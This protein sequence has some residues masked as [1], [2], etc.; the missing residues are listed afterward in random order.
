MTPRRLALVV[1]LA[2]AVAAPRASASMDVTPGW[3]TSSP[4]GRSLAAHFV[5]RAGDKLLVGGGWDGTFLATAWAY[6]AASD[7]WQPA[8]AMNQARGNATAT[9][10][11]D[12]R[13]LVAGGFAPC[14]PLASA[15]I[16]DPALDRWKTVA[17]MAAARTDH[18]AVRLA[19]G[20]VLVLGGSIDGA[21]TATATIYDP[22]SDKWSAAAPMTT[23]RMH[24]TATLLPNGRVLV[25]GGQVGNDALAS[26]EV[27]DPT[28]NQWNP[29][30]PM[31]VGR[32]VHTATLLPNGR[33]LVVG[34]R[35]SIT[36]AT[37]SAELFD[38]AGPSWSSA[39]TMSAGRDGHAAILLANGDVL[40]AGSEYFGGAATTSEIYHPQRNAWDPPESMH[41]G[42]RRHGVGGLLLDGRVVLV[43]GD[44]NYAASV[45]TVRWTPRTTQ[46]YP[47][48]VWDLGNQALG[49]SGAPQEL[50]VTNT[51]DQPLLFSGATTVG[52]SAAEFKVAPGGC[53]TA[54]VMPGQSCQ[55]G[56][57]FTP[58]APGQRRA[59]FTFTSNAN[60]WP[61]PSID[62]KG[63]GVS[64][65]PAPTSTTTP[66]PTPEA[67]TE[68]TPGPHP[69]PS[70]TPLIPAPEATR[71]PVPSARSATASIVFKNA[72]RIARPLQATRCRGKITLELRKGPVRLARRT[73]T[74]DRRCRFGTTFTVQRSRIG[75][76]KSLTVVAHFHG[77]RY[78]GATTNR[79]KV[80]V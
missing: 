66:S 44:G 59:T 6:S 3:H 27:Y 45:D 43:G 53:L 35:S 34:G 70:A 56:L 22:A 2:L 51:G 50:T 68:P 32:F 14:C 12:G 76:A 42:T 4:L 10:L 29:V 79:F 47:T 25:T 40:I 8:A 39:G 61:L 38:P 24:A 57:R 62:V 28:S 31:S 26:A 23:A 30:G 5:A 78:L 7:F 36:A 65:T 37:G 21:M 1:V 63:V 80:A 75:G 46:S 33:V 52:A 67:T 20:R 16:Y 49:G 17:P 55:L 72:Y 48:A 73:T 18:A 77:N 71:T 64:P 54:V 13:L 19:T 60:S 69:E 58:L 15:E 74:L 9:T 11:S 41:A